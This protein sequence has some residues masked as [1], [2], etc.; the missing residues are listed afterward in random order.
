MLPIVVG[1]V[2][3]VLVP[4]A[5]ALA[6]VRLSRS[7]TGYEAYLKVLRR[8]VVVALLCIDG[9]LLV[10]RLD[11]GPFEGFWLLPSS[12]FKV[13]AGDK[14][15]RDTAMRKLRELRFGVELHVGQALTEP[16]NCLHNIDVSYARRIGIMPTDIHIYECFVDVP[17]QVPSTTDVRWCSPE[18]IAELDWIH[19]LMAPIVTRYFKK[20]ALGE[21][22]AGRAVIDEEVAKV[23]RG[24]VERGER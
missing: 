17:P 19:P 7:K 5:L 22:I 18:E 6:V 4:I 10:V 9:K 14:S 1:F 24:R 8:P 23:I 12:Y 2:V 16:G 20:P 15:T 21:E 13:E 11:R 3:L